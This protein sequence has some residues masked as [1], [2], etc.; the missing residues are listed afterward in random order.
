MVRYFLLATELVSLL[1]ACGQ[2]A[3]QAN[4]TEEPGTFDSDSL[5]ADASTWGGPGPQGVS[6]TIP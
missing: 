3:A 4:E 6:M 1:A 2:V 5:G